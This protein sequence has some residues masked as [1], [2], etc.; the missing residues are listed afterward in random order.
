MLNIENKGNITFINYKQI[1]FSLPAQLIAIV[2]VSLAFGDF[3]PE[4][5]KA[6]FLS[7]SLSIK[8][9]LIFILPFIIFSFAFYSFDNGF[10]W[11]NTNQTI[12][13]D[14]INNKIVFNSKPEIN[15]KT[16]LQNGRAYMQQVFKQYLA[17]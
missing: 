10:G 5:L 4:I 17:Y 11:V 9:V 12:V 1:L 7:I 16:N 6:F 15:P 14:N 2:L 8:S 13:Q 3:V